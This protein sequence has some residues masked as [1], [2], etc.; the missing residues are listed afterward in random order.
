METKNMGVAWV[1]MGVCGCGKSA[2]GS[3]LAARLGLPFIEGD[4]FHSE[5]NVDKMRAGI[6]LT[7]TD[8]AGW[9]RALRAE[10]AAA[11]EKGIV[12]SCSALK[13]AYRDVL[14]GEGGHGPQVRFVHLDG[15]RALLDARVRARPGH[16]MPASL[17]D[18]QLQTL[19]RLQPDEA[20]M[21]L[22]IRAPLDEL[23]A[24]VLA[25]AEA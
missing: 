15:E 4:D 25:R 5:E 23:L 12:L 22:D 9:L 19:E 21:T 16:Y 18:S 10:L 1:V 2:L 3:Q 17:L 6:P 11:G 14:R 20:G 24:Q 8:R 7:D 13:R